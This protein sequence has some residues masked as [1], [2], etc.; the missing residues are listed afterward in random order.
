MNPLPASRV[1]FAALALSFA[2]QA[3]GFVPKPLT[4]DTSTATDWKI[5]NG[6][7][8]FDWDST[9]GSV[10]GVRYGAD[11]TNLVDTTNLGGDGN[12]K[13]LYMDNTGIGSGTV[14]A[15]YR[16]DS[17]RYLDWWLTTASNA[18]NAF[19][20]TQHFIVFPSDPG[21][22]T[23]IVFQHGAA[24]IAGSLGQVQ[25]VFRV[26]LT[27]F[28]NTYSYNSGLN[29]LGAALI[30]QPD[31]SVTGTT[32]PGRQVQN[33]AVDLHGLPLP[34]GFVREFYTKYDY[35]SYEYLHELHGVYGATY[36]AW[37]EFA[38]QDTLV[39]GP[40]K[41][42]LIFTNN[43]VMGEFLSDHLAYNVGYTPPQGVASIRIFGPVY[44]RF[45]Q[46][47][48][49]QMFNDALDSMSGLDALYDRDAVLIDAG[50]VPSFNRGGVAPTIAGGG[51]SAANTAWAVLGDNQANFQFTNLGYQYWT[52]NNAGGTA[53]L[54]GVAPGTYRLSSY[55]LGQ[56][57]EA[58]VDNVAVAPGRTTTL[59]TAFTP[60]NFGSAAPVW[61]I[62]TPNR[63]ADKF[64]HGTDSSGADDREYQGNWNYWSDFAAN[65]GAV[66][67]YAT[68]VGATPATNDLTKWNYVQW[69]TFDP[70]LYAGIYNAADDTTDGYKY[71]C[72]AYVGNPATANCPPWQV[73]FTTT[74]AQQAQG[75][76]V[77][78]SVGL[79]A[80]DANLTVSLNGH[81]LS[82][83]G[84][85]T[86]KTSDAAVRSGLAGTYQWVVF[87]WPT[88][89]L[90]AAAASNEITLAVSGSSLMYDALRME[91]T[92]TSA[93]PATRGW[94]D[95]EFVTAGTYVP[96]NDAVPNP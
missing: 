84:L 50:Y 89:D 13:G 33:A 26:S 66:V 95:Y 51:S 44:F 52:A 78:L 2:S 88:S 55:V 62:G 7:M 96:A 34:A 24:D 83:N 15:G 17:G 3:M 75:Q 37:A 60:E 41:Q 11:P 5:T 67:Y 46:G 6:A 35:S 59:A 72:P 71:I 76:Y 1:V 63:S 10:W 74:A 36:G 92:N 70:G 4:I 25:Y 85:S 8:R 57:G 12:P 94:N 43:I 90:A 80:T 58:R 69:P 77:V 93:A 87:Q 40:V 42:D 32:D 29:N 27:E 56:W 22:H 91:I 39:G 86:V 81:T 19:T 49:D 54:T 73:Y 38:R 53:A 21:I 65:R 14:T 64:L 82:W 79:A 16:L 48:P 23:Y 28:T 47:T 9:N 18:S 20:Y 68:P 30:P 45:N 61:T 31:P